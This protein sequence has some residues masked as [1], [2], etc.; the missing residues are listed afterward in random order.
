MVVTGITAI[1]FVIGQFIDPLLTSRALNLSSLVIVL[2][3]TFWAAVWGLVGMFLAVPLM[4]V[5]LVVCS[6]V[7]ELQAVAVLL[8]K[9]GSLTRLK[10]DR[11]S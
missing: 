4:V 2:S 10:A 5:V 3:L 6:H 7:P 1:Q 9:D 11:A 8:S